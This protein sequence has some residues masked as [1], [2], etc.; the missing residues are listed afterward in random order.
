MPR[1]CTALDE[2]QPCTY[3]ALSGQR[4]CC[5]HQPQGLA[6]HQCEYFNRRGERCRALTM[7]GQDHCFSHSPR[8]RR[9]KSPAVPINPRTRCQKA[10]RNR[11]IFSNMPLS[12]MTLQTALQKQQLAGVPWGVGD[13]SHSRAIAPIPQQKA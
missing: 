7:R 2:G 3:R 12:Q 4:F 10:R 11:L 8:N 9:A 13:S 6:N 1:F 5:G